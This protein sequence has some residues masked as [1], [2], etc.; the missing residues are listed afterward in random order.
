MMVWIWICVFFY[1]LFYFKVVRAE[2]EWDGMWWGGHNIIYCGD[3]SLCAACERNG[4]EKV[5]G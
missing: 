5:K 2:C 4:E 1:I 3:G